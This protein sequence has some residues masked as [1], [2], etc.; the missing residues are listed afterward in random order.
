[1]AGVVPQLEDVPL[2][3][4]TEHRQGR[5]VEVQ[6]GARGGGQAQENQGERAQ[7]VAVAEGDHTAIGNSVQLFQEGGRPRLHLLD[8]LPVG[9]AVAPQVPIR[10]A[11]VDLPGSDPFVV[12]VVPLDKE[13]I[14]GGFREAGQLSGSDRAPKRA[15]IDLAEALL[16][17]SFPKAPGPLLPLG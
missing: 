10:P 17:K 12:A 2:L 16:G 13:W 4:P 8:R 15:R 5:G 7:K 3:S 14:D 11:L 6:A 9:T 1:M